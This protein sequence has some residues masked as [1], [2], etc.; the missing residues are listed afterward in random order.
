MK[1]RDLMTSIPESVT[2]D[3]PV[4]DAAEIMEDLEVG[5]VPVVEGP[6][7]LRLVGAITDR[8]LAVRHVAG[9]HGPECPIRRDMT[10]RQGSDH[11]VTV[12]PE[13]TVDHVLDQMARHQLRRVPVV[14]DGDQRLVGIVA[15]AD[16]ARR[17]GS[18]HPVEVERLLEAISRPSDH[19]SVVPAAQ[20]S[21]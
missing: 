4:T 1:V 16:V 19:K 3:Q 9:G 12:R 5:C 14:E 21:K 17:F 15:L 10:A 2:P 8:D 6:E 11:F 7:S 13:D 18:E 20:T